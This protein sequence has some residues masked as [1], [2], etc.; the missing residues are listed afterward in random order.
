MTVIFQKACVFQRGNPAQWEGTSSVRTSI[1]SIWKSEPYMLDACLG[2]VAHTNTLI[3]RSDAVCSWACYGQ[4]K[5][6]NAF[7]NAFTVSLKK[8]T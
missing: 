6:R 3:T 8:Q 7:K 1:L 5:A 4:C 2:N